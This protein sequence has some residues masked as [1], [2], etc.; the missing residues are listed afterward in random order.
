MRVCEA[1]RNRPCFRDEASKGNFALFEMIK[2]GQLQRRVGLRE[3]MKSM[4]TGRWLDWDPT[5]CFLLFKRD[6]QPFS[7]DQM[8]PFADDVKIAEPGS[9]S[10]STAHLKLE[11]GTTIVHYNKSMKQLNE[12]H[13]DDVL[14]FMDHETA[15]KP[16]TSFTLTFILT[17][18]SFKFKSKFIGYCIA[19]RDNNQRVQWLNSVLSSQLD[20]QALPSPLLQI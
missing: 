2:C 12:W 8:Y 1:A 20:F 6:P 7:F 3:K 13:V 15:R 19:F 10:F 14:W 16:P 18:K 11:T 17:K 9:K 4:V 5:D